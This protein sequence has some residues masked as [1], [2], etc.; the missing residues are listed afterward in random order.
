MSI[1]KL[2]ILLKKISVT[3]GLFLLNDKIL[4][5]DN[6]ISPATNNVSITFY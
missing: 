4:L 5:F 1:L 6:F 3:I 2:I